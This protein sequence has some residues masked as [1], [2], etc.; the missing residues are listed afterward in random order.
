MSSYSHATFLFGQKHIF[1]WPLFWRK[2]TLPVTSNMS[3][4]TLAHNCSIWAWSS[5]NNTIIAKFTIIGTLVR[6]AS[7][8][9]LSTRSILQICFTLRH[10]C[11]SKSSF[12]LNYFVIT[13]FSNYKINTCSLWTNWELQKIP[14]KYSN[15]YLYFIKY[16]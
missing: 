4:C 16:M 11:V 15:I 14:N 7:E 5:P 12:L 3:L 13:Y 1:A 8:A 9:S 6:P 10:K 2:L